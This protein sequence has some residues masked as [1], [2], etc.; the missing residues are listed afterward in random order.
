MGELEGEG[1]WIFE[2][3]NGITTVKY[4]WVVKTNSVLMNF[5]APV[6]KP[7]FEWNHDVVMQWGQAGLA[8]YLNCNIIK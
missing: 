7:L 2:Y 6:L 5:L 1:N 4:Y 3:E 8:K